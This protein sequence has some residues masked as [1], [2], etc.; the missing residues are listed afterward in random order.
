MDETIES[1]TPE[2]VRELRQK[3]DLSQRKFWGQCGYTV[4]QGSTF[5]R[6]IHNQDNRHM[7]QAVFM[8]HVLGIPLFDS[9]ALSEWATNAEIGNSLASAMTKKE[10]AGAKA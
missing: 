4:Q 6:G 3:L 2:R 5:E 9:Q 1:M 10:K 8:R 7:K